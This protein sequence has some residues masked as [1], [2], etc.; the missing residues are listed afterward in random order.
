MDEVQKLAAL[1]QR[2]GANPAQAG[3]MARQLL[4][5]AE[6]IATERGQ[7]REEALDR[8]LRLTIQGASGE[9]PPEFQPPDQNSSDKPAK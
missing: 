2:L 7:S 6:Q 8:L 3:T 9:V 4:K 1:C 5:R